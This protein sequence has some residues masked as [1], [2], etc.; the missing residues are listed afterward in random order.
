MVRQNCDGQISCI[1][2]ILGK[3]GF[4]AGFGK[5]GTHFVQFI[6][7]RVRADPNPVEVLS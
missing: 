3:L 5:L 1:T 7:F 2:P 6:D 4:D